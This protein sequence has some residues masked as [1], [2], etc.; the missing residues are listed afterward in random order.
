[1]K[2]S[3]IHILGVVYKKDIDDLRESP[4]LGVMLLQRRGARLSYSDPYVPHLLRWRILKALW[5]RSGA[6]LRPTRGWRPKHLS[7]RMFLAALTERNA[8]LLR[9]VGVE[10]ALPVG[11]KPD[12]NRRMMRLEKRIRALEARS[13]K[14]SVV[15]CFAYGSTREERRA[16]TRL[17][18]AIN[19]AIAPLEVDHLDFVPSA[20][21]T[22]LLE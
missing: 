13:T 4:A 20:N 22:G 18:S 12:R 11:A 6:C 9:S 19:Q 3:H 17:R 15:L 14:D 10:T 2:G 21:W 1:V 8:D 16:F 5:R 7:S